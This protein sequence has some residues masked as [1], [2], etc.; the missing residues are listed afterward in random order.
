MKI[1][2]VVLKLL[3]LGALFIA[4]NHNL[5]LNDNTEREIFFNYYVSWISNLFHQGVDVTGYVIKFEWL[6]RANE[7]YMIN[8]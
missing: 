4:S 3:F 5:H 2:M 8:N 7:T 6:P 1:T